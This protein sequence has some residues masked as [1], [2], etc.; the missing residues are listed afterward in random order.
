[1]VNYWTNAAWDDVAA[2]CFC[3]ISL[4]RFSSAAFWREA[5]SSSARRLASRVGVARKHGARN[6]ASDAHD[7]PSPAPDSASSVASVWRLRMQEAK[8]SFRGATI[9]PDRR[10]AGCGATAPGVWLPARWATR[11]DPMETPRAE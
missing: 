11:V 2:G 5:I 9:A 1:M 4:C 7:Y 10:R 3:P 6:M 8:D